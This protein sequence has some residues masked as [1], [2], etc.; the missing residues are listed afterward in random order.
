VRALLAKAV[1]PTF[2][3]PAGRPAR[4]IPP[5]PF[6]ICNEIYQGW[7]L[8]DT[9]AH[10]AA[11]GYDAVELAPFTL[12]RLATDLGEK[13]RQRIRDTVRRAGLKVAGL[14]WLLA[15][16]EGFHLTHPDAGVRQRTTA[17]LRA[18]I[19]TAGSLF[20]ARRNNAV[21][22]AGCHRRRRGIGRQ[23]F[24]ATW[25]DRRKIAERCSVLN[26]SRRRKRISS[27]PRRTRVVSLRRS[28]AVRSESSLM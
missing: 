3:L 27:T 16:T 21:C 9:C 8:E 17:Y 22:S 6:A 15:H 24:F 25:S 13:D 10:A 18:P 14:H 20:S 4:N 2:A 1:S 12:A 26:P 7:S 19:S 28:T 11:S 5:V 23:R